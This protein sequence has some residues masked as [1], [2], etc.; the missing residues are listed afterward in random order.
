VIKAWRKKKLKML[1]RIFGPRRKYVSGSGEN[2][3]II[4]LENCIPHP[5]NF[6]S[7]NREE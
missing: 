3:I 4:C 7:L 2:Y 1:R 6:G 5:V